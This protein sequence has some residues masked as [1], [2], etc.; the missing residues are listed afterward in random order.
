MDKRVD[1]EIRELICEI[2]LFVILLLVMVP[3]CVNASNNYK[4]ST[5]KIQNCVDM[6]VSINSVDGKKFVVL[7]NYGEKEVNINLV[8]KIREFSN[9]YMIKLGNRDIYLSDLERTSDGEFYYYDLG[10]YTISKKEEIE[11]KIVLVGD[12]IYNDNVSYSFV[13]EVLYC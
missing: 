5:S 11:Y 12:E 9:E 4:E 6:S 10:D 13:A 2:I 1:N 7:D 8:L 3:I